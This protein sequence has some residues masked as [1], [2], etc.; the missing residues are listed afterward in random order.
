MPPKK[1]VKEKQVK[2]DE[3]EEMVLSYMK[4][5]NRPYACADVVANLK[6]KVPKTLAVKIL[7]VLAEKGQLSTKTYGK[8]HLYLYNQS[9]LS[10]LDKEEL[11]SLDENIKTTQTKLDERRKILKSLQTELTASEA[12][13]KTL[14][15]GKE[16]DR[17][18]T[19]NEITLRALLPFRG[20]SDDQPTVIPMS[21]NDTKK[22]DAEF[23]KWR[24]EWVDRRKIYKELIGFLAEG[25]LINDVKTFEEELGV[26]PDDEIAIATEQ[27][28]FCKPLPVIRGRP[29]AVGGLPKPGNVGLTEKGVKRTASVIGVGSQD[30][31][32]K[33]K[34]KKEK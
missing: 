21:A 11:T 30:D 31:A 19:Q 2:G 8:Q 32:K 17:I 34:V 15:L 14:E 12:R 5:V 3:A 10:V 13:P 33:K 18:K 28:E 7:A 20:A 16:I 29:K 4:D 22:I 25:G 26:A 27:G 24:K 9:L 6:N 23:T 1:E